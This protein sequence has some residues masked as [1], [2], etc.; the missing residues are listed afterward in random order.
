MGQVNLIPKSQAQEEPEQPG[1]PGQRDGAETCRMVSYGKLMKYARMI[2]LFMTTMLSPLLISAST[3]F[4][5]TGPQSDGYA[6]ENQVLGASWTQTGSYQDVH[7]SA[8]LQIVFPNSPF[9]VTAYLTTSIGPGTTVSDLVAVNVV[10]VQSPT[11]PTTVVLM[12]IPFLPSGTY[13]FTLFS[14]TRS[15][16]DN[17]NIP[18]ITTDSGV[19]RNSDYYVFGADPNYVPASTFSS[20]CCPPD[21]LIDVSGSAVPEPGTAVPG[22][23]LAGWLVL[24]LRFR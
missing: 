23:I 7:I 24:K 21:L 22:F 12:S 4:S 10:T 9:L 1:V 13:Y 2:A 11:T 6:L 5:V 20:I 3:I 19:T 18:T 8:P 14:P 15:G 16:W 17:T